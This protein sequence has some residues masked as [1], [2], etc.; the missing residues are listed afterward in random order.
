MAKAK[1]ADLDWQHLGFGYRDLPYSWHAEY[2]DGKWVNGG[3]TTES[4]LVF[5]EAAQ[6]LHYGQEVFEGL[7]AY[8][9]KDGKVQ[10][11][12]PL[13]NAKRLNN[14]ADR[15]LMPHYPEEKF[16]EA[17]KAVVKA[18]EDFVPPYGS[19]GTL[20]IRPFMVGT[21]PL[22]GVTPAENFV[23]HVYATPVG[24]YVKGLTPMP[25]VLSKYDRAAPAGTGQAKTAGNYAA[26][27]LPEMAAKKAGYADALYLD[28]KEHKYVDEFSGA[29]F[30]GV[31]KDGQF[32]TPKSNSILPSITKRSLLQVAE[33]LG[34]NPVE[35]KLTLEDLDD[36]AEAGA[37]GTAAVISPVGSLTDLEGKKHVFY[38][39]TEVGPVTTKLYEALFNVQVGD[40][41][42]KHGWVEPVD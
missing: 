23:F 28:P 35:K 38:S 26:S 33:D 12:R 40:A 8:R 16:L 20:Y 15:L 22:V 34:L 36:L 30:F 14:S 13:E 29:N 6:V 25:Y 1:A 18:N 4:N 41:E 7:K 42:D 5:N 3:L 21:Q 10:L 2:A 19:G 17:V 37:M 11:F 9:T 24:A 27:L 39:E 31:T 32:V